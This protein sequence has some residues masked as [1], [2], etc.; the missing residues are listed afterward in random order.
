M[1]GSVAGQVVS[2]TGRGQ[3]NR[4]A[5]EGEGPHSHEPRLR[6]STEHKRRWAGSRCDLLYSQRVRFLLLAR[7]EVRYREGCVGRWYLWSL[8][9]Y[10]RYQIHSLKVILIPLQR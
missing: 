10:T 4:P 8:S 7:T 2:A 5:R 6:M 9:F 1:Q 3:G